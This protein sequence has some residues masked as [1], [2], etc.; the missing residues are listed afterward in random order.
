MT[1]MIVLAPFLPV[2]VYAAGALLAEFLLKEM[3]DI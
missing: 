2:T 1:R 3:L